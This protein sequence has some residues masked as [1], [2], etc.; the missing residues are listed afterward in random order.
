VGYNETSKAYKVYIP[1]QWKVVV[2]RDVKFDKDAWSSK[3]LEPPAVAKEIK[4]LAAPKVDL[5]KSEDQKNQIQI[6]KLS[7][8]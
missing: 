8:V 7:E 5:Q 4:E 1:S 6:R 3:F 2:S